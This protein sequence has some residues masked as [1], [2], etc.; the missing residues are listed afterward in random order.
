MERVFSNL[1]RFDFPHRRKDRGISHT[2]LLVRKQGNLLVC[3]CNNGSSVVDYY[4]EIEKLGGIGLQLVP[5]FHDAKRGDLHQQLFDRFGCELCYHEA[6]R[7][8]MRT[9]TKCPARMFGDEGLK[10]GLDLEAFFFPGHTPGMSIFRWKHRAKPFLFPSHVIGL[11]D[12]EWGVSFAPHIAPRQKGRFTEL[13]KT[14]VDYWARGNSTDGTDTVHRLSDS[15]KKA[16][17]RILRSKLEWKPTQSGRLRVVTGHQPV[18]KVLSEDKR[19][20]ID[21]V[22]AYGTCRIETIEDHIESANVAFFLNH[23]RALAPGHPFAGKLRT[24]VEKGGGLWI[25]DARQKSKHSWLVNSHPFPE[26]SVRTFLAS[27]KTKGIEQDLVSGDKHSA[28]SLPKGKRFST[29][30]EVGMAFEPGKA[31]TV[32]L[33]NSGGEAVGVV[34]KVGKGRVA[35]TG[36]HHGLK[37]PVSDVERKLLPALVSWLGGKS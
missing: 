27:G 8:G 3:H 26:V 29:Q 28:R 25:S 10:L 20:D 34:G 1:Y 9:K 31:G 33:R 7:P 23:S 2:Y 35:L 19:F 4:D 22:P 11:H 15:E 24:F 12:G 21:E 30:A 18:L 17:Q 13:A 14:G 32:L 16:L 36:F 5:H 6:E 37:T